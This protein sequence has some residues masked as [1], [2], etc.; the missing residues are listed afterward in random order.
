MNF[1]FDVCSLILLGS[2]LNTNTLSFPF[3][4][5]TGKEGPERILTT[6]ACFF[7]YEMHLVNT[8]VLLEIHILNL[9]VQ[10]S[11]LL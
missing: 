8:L 6:L 1:I 10:H 4:S 5:Q 2:R 11:I 3:P 7:Q 9:L